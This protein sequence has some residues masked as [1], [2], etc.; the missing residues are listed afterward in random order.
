MASDGETRR[1]DPGPTILTWGDAETEAWKAW[2]LGFA[3]AGA[4]DLATLL[5]V[6]VTKKDTPDSLR[7]RRAELLARKL[8]KLGPM[9]ESI[10]MRIGLRLE[11][12]LTEEYARLRPTHG[13]ELVT[14][15]VV[16]VHPSG[17]LAATP[18]AW[19]WRLDAPEVRWPVQLKAYSEFCRAW[20]KDGAVPVHLQVQ[21]QAEA[22]CAG[23]PRGS[24]FVLT[25]NAE[26]C[27][28]GDIEADREFEALAVAKCREFASEVEAGRKNS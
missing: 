7:A 19:T 18:D 8:G 6:T 10:G 13:V 24:Y 9:E 1:M 28:F 11:K 17:V 23:A 14:G 3:G 21:V 5:E 26:P 22:A 16:H 15:K 27:F 12:L 25:G 20:F 2:R 4:S